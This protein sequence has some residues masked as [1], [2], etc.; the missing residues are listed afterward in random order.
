MDSLGHAV[1]EDSS[2]LFTA[3]QHVLIAQYA[4]DASFQPGISVPALINITRAPTITGVQSNI[5]TVTAGQSITLS[6]SVV[7]ALATYGGPLTGTITFTAG[8]Q[9][10]GPPVAVSSAVDP[11]TNLMTGTASMPIP[12]LPLGPNSITATYSG[13]VNYADSTSQTLAVNVVSTTPSC[14]VSNFTADPNPYLID[15]A[16]PIRISITANCAYDLRDGAPNGGLQLSGTG[17]ATTLYASPD[18]FYLQASGDNTPAGTLQT[19]VVEQYNFGYPCEVY[20]FA[21]TPNPIISP[22]LSGSTTVSAAAGC[23]FTIRSG[24]PVGPILASS[25]TNSNVN[26][27][28][29]ATTGNSVTDGTQFYMVGPGLDNPPTLASLTVRVLKSQPACYVAQ[30]SASPQRILTP[31][32]LGV[33][34]ITA[35]A[36]CAFDIRVGRPDGTVFVSAS[37]YASTQTGAWVSEGMTFYLQRAGDTT[38]AGTLA[39]TTVLL[40]TGDQSLC[41]SPGGTPAHCSGAR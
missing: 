18:T 7:S 31:G 38:A 8:G 20:G 37:G 25:S 14:V 10:V 6:A 5:T 21:A 11:N 2:V 29:T 15:A 22:T 39:T 32:P 1:S 19:L 28:A 12:S 27:V 9:R 16:T 17:T 13:D 3:G 34:T 24:S 41:G 35:L 36:G 40:L 30:F 4:G 23:N 26:Y 33:T